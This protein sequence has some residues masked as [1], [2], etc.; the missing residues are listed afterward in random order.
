MKDPRDNR[1]HTD[2]DGKQ[3]L[4]DEKG[5]LMKDEQ[6]KNIPPSQSRVISKPGEFTEHDTSQGHCG[7]CGSLYC[8]GNCFK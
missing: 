7:L 2:D 6:G 1:I 4:K 8:R 5:E 3:W